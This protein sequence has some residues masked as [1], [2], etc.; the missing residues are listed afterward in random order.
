MF[1]QDTWLVS[2]HRPKAPFM[3]QPWQQGYREHQALTMVQS[4]CWPTVILLTVICVKWESKSNV[5]GTCSISTIRVT[6]VN[7][8]NFW[9]SH[10]NDST[11]WQ[12]VKQDVRIKLRG[13]YSNFCSGIL[14]LNLEKHN[15]VV[16]AKLRRL[17]S[18]NCDQNV[19]FNKLNSF[20]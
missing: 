6:V 8:K 16:T 11:Y 3:P 2:M 19:N 17:W 4:P 20:T 12:I 7:D 18:M 1:L 14:L 15:T 10:C 9:V 13:P 5:F